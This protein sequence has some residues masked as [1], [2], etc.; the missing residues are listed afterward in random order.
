MELNCRTPTQCPLRTGALLSV[1]NPHIRCHSVEKSR[2][3]NS[4]PLVGRLKKQESFFPSIACLSP[5]LDV[6]RSKDLLSFISTQLPFLTRTFH[7]IS[8]Q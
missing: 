4:F 8:A 5:P 2:G 6:T 3:K 1:G 7:L